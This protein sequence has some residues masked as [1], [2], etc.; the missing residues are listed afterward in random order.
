MDWG[1]PR[2]GGTYGAH[3]ST[4]HAIEHLSTPDI[5]AYLVKLNRYSSLE[6]E[7]LWADGHSP[8]W[9]RPWLLPPTAALHLVL[10][11]ATIRRP[12]PAGSGDWLVLDPPARLVL[13]VVSVLFFF[14]SFYAVSYLRHHA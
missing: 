2:N 7:Q 9:W 10:T 1:S 12:E 4:K 6:A 5:D 14:C 11:L 3:R 8:S 13:L